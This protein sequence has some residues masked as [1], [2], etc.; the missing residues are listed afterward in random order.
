V[1]IVGLGEPTS[2]LDSQTAWSICVLLRKLVD[3]GQAV[4][5]TIHQP[6][7]QIFE[8]LD[9]LLLI[10]RQ[11]QTLYFGE[12]GPH[13]TSVIHYF[14]ETGALAFLGTSINPA[15]WILEVTHGFDFDQLS[16]KC[17]E[18][19]QR[20]QSASQLFG[21]TSEKNGDAVESSSV[22]TIEN[23]YA[24]PL[25]QQLVP[26]HEAGSH[27]VLEASILYVLENGFVHRTCK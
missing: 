10:S 27:R 22:Q 25:P 23:E 18:S 5:C 3:H 15:E 1:G 16:T 2:G 9:R 19:V 24:A 8:M 17:I 14:E 20:Q 4:L 12:I 13:A 7:A 6:S 21:S 26:H 11:G